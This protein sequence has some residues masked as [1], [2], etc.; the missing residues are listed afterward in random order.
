MEQQRYE[1]SEDGFVSGEPPQADQVEACRVWLKKN[2]EP[3]WTDCRGSYGLKH[4]VESDLDTY[5]SNG[6]LLAAA[7]SMGLRVEST[8]IN[9]NVY[10]KVIPREIRR[11]F[12]EKC[13]FGSELTAPA[14]EVRK[15]FDPY[16][17]GPNSLFIAPQTVHRMLILRG[18]MKA[19]K[20][21]NGKPC[22]AWIGVGLI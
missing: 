20:L 22:K 9:G 18:C 5:I 11:F 7:V 6:A 21:Y 17:G 10:V 13:A 3:S 14:A 2:A 1:I 12:S 19:W 15:A 4:E 8:G 16:I